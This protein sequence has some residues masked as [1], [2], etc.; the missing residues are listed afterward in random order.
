MAKA[1][2]EMTVHIDTKPMLSAIKEAMDSVKSEIMGDLPERVAKLEFAMNEI[3][4]TK[5]D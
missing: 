2:L 3:M 5:G 4:A 1:E